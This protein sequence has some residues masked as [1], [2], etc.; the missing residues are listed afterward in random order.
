MDNSEPALQRLLSRSSALCNFHDVNVVFVIALYKL[1][2]LSQKHVCIS[3]LC[4]ATW[5]RRPFCKPW[6][7]KDPHKVDNAFS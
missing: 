7:I 2:N 6:T 4:T 1:Q 3:R 5:L